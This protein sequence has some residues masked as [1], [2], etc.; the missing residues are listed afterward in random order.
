MYPNMTKF[1]PFILDNTGFFINDQGF[2][3]TGDHLSYLVAF[4][5]SNIFQICYRDSFP[6]LQG[7]T[8]ELRK[9]FFEQVKIPNNLLP[10]VVK[11]TIRS[12]FLSLL[13]FY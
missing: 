6:E 9:I 2:I 1:M 12:V 3:I 10:N 11:H 5:N 4:F 13:Y 8:R 7:G